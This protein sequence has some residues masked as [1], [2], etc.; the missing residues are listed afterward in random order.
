[1]KAG[2]N[3]DTIGNFVERASRYVLAGILGAA[4]MWGVLGGHYVYYEHEF[5]IIR[6]NRITQEVCTNSLDRSGW[7]CSASKP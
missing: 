6:V 4:L 5:V 2:F 1:M 7:V 3:L